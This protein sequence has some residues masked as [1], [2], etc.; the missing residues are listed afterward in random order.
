MADFDYSAFDPEQSSV[1]QAAQAEIDRRN[2]DKSSKLSAIA[3]P[4]LGVIGAI[5]GGLAGGPAGAGLGLTAGKTAAGAL[6]GNTS[7][8]PGMDQLRG[9]LD[10]YG[11]QTQSDAAVPQSASVGASDAW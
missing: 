2:G 7:K 9:A 1:Q 4:S 8:F 6:T 3:G 10:L 11:K 5:I